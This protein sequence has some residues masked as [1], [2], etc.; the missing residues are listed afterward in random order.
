M[1][2]Q[3]FV[4]SLLTWPQV[5]KQ[6]DAEKLRVADLITQKDTI[7]QKAATT[8]AELESQAHVT[9]ADLEAK[10]AIAEAAATT[11]QNE[12][13]ELKDNLAKEKDANANGWVIKSAQLK[14]ELDEQK[15]SLTK[16]HEEEIAKLKQE[17]KDDLNEQTRAFVGLQESLNLKMTADNATLVEE[18]ANLKKAWDEDKARFQ[19]M[20]DDLRS[21][22]QGMEQEKG[23]LEKIVEEFRD[24]TDV[25]SK[26]DM[27]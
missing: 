10:L 3:T 21:V 8:R 12:N 27:A 17:H 13:E 25:K 15:A 1:L 26:G 7:A 16:G 18:I 11:A 20:I 19:K 6:L 2:A 23:R 24:G 5:Q 22:A 4:A 14:A 9:K